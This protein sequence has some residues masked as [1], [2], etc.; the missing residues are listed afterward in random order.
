MK[1]IH[2]EGRDDTTGPEVA[3]SRTRYR[4]R[5]RGRREKEEK[6]KRKKRGSGLESGEGTARGEIR[7]RGC[8]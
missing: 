3:D 2:Q 1:N 7:Y 8:S 4:R 5:G 6:K